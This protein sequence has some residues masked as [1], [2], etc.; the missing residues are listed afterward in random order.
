MVRI[1]V[2]VDD[3]GGGGDLPG[4]HGWSAFVECAAGA[5]LF[6]TGQSELFAENAERLGVRLSRAGHIVLSHGHYDHT[7]GLG[8]ALAEVPT[9]AVVA[10]EAAFVDRYA[11]DGAAVRSIGSPIGLQAVRDSGAWLSLSADPVDLPCG[12]ITT[13]QIPRVTDFETVT[14]S[15]HLEGADGPH[16]PVPDDLAVLTAVHGGAVLL[17]GCAHAGLVNTLIY[18]AERWPERPVVAVV[19]GLHMVGASPERIERTLD[20]LEDLG[21]PD[22]WP[23]HCT[24]GP[25]VGALSARFP[26]HVHPCH[27]GTV[28]EYPAD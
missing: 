4:E 24:G 7:G 23:S 2:L 14:A 13:G 3:V 12:A 22:I 6:D 8:R 20:F 16:D 11:A 1:T 10:H 19:G 17:C 21:P 27:V 25:A 5:F 28:L 26:D 9:A 18:V 15:F